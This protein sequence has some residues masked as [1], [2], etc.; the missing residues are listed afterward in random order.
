MKY[1]KQEVL[2]RINNAYTDIDEVNMILDTYGYYRWSNGYTKHS[3][4]DIVDTI[5]KDNPAVVPIKVRLVGNKV[6]TYYTSWERTEKHLKD[7]ASHYY[8]NKAW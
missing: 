2:D 1:T 6:I 8:Y 5:N 4:Y 7:V 3:D